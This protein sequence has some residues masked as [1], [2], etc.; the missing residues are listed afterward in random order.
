MCTGIG[1]HG[2]RGRVE[3]ELCAWRTELCVEIGRR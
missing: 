2:G 3:I 1:D